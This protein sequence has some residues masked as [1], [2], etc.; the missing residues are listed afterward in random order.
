MSCRVQIHCFVLCDTVLCCL[1]LDVLCH[2]VC[3][4]I[5]YWVVVCC[6]IFLSDSVVLY[7]AVLDCSILCGWVVSYCVVLRCSMFWCA[8]L[9]YVTLC[10]V[11]WLWWLLHTAQGRDDVTGEPL[12]QHADDRPEALQARLRHYKDVAKPVMNLYKWVKVATSPSSY[13]MI[14]ALLHQSLYRTSV[15]DCAAYT[16]NKNP[17]QP[18]MMSDIPQNGEVLKAGKAY[19]SATQKQQANRLV[20]CKYNYKLAV[21]TCLI[22]CTIIALHRYTLDTSHVGRTPPPPLHSTFNHLSRG[23]MLCICFMCWTSAVFFVTKVP[24]H[25]V[26]VLGYRHRPHLALHQLSSQH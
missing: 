8:I 3:C 14:T 10:Y 12:I 9:Y 5:L 16:Y 15:S 2:G 21:C 6:T 19:Y 7:C 18:V 24:R 26:P 1:D 22:P 17:I 4:T 25:P 23:K 13:P 11:V 20:P